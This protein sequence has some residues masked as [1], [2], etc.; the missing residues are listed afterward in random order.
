MELRRTQL[1][2]AVGAALLVGGTAAQAQVGAG[3]QGI[4]VQL[5]GQVNRAIMWADDGHRSKAFFVDGE[6]SGTRFGINGTS[7]VMPGLKAG[8]KFEVE[9]QS[10]SSDSVN[11]ESPTDNPGLA[12]R[13]FDVFLEG[14]WGRVNLGQG[15]GAADDASTVD[16]SGTGLADGVCTCDWGGKIF[17]RDSAG[18][19]LGTNV[20]AVFS[21]QDFESRYDRVMYT[22]PVFG[23]FRAQVGTGQKST[24]GEVN[25]ASL[26]YAGKL[27][28]DI[29]AAI[30]WSDEKTGSNLAGV[31]IPS[32]TTVGGSVSWLHA[33]GFSVTLAHTNQEFS[34][35]PGREDGKHTW[36]KVGYKFGKNAVSVSYGQTENISQNDDEGKVFGA[37][38]VY[39]PV[40]WAEF[41]VNYHMFQLD[42]PG[43][44]VED[45]M[46]AAVGT[47]IRF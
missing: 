36:G 11:F 20:G 43:V 10:N 8:A 7:N 13:W 39:N 45:I 25:E 34:A 2:A 29:Q 16:L 31:E 30:G 14:A 28:G 17:F 12:E 15:S 44:D 33:S 47:R 19:V 32:N 4:Q 9:Y 27:M 41:Y 5:Y 35:A 42:R 37:G 23:G 3:Q 24:A 46:V 21:N 18:G 38:Y 22:T 1:A 40:N 6:S 26:W